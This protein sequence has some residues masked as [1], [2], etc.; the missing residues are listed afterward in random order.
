MGAKEIFPECALG[1]RPHQRFTGYRSN[2]AGSH[3][4]HTGKRKKRV[5][6]AHQD[7][8]PQQQ[9]SVDSIKLHTGVW[10]AMTHSRERRRG[11]HEQV[12]GRK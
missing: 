9:K 1:S 8:D 11:K 3:Q 5:G 6:R 4:K 7:G 2:K 12:S 10:S